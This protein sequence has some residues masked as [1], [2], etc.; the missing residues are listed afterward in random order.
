M[1]AEWNGPGSLLRPRCHMSLRPRKDAWMASPQRH[2]SFTHD[3]RPIFELP[4]IGAVLWDASGRV[5]EA[6]ERF[7]EITGYSRE[8]LQSGRLDWRRMTPVEWSSLDAASISQLLAEGSTREVEKE[9]VHR[10]GHRVVVQLSSVAVPG[11]GKRFLSLVVDVTGRRLAEREREEALERE[12]TA[13]EQAEAA[14]R[15]RDEILA[16]VSHDLRNPLGTISMTAGLLE[17]EADDDRRRT[18][19]D[20]LRRAVSRMGRL[21]HDL[22]DVNQIESGKLVISPAPVDA[23]SLMDEARPGLDLEAAQNRQ[24]LEWSAPREPLVVM[25][26]HV[27]IAQVIANLVGNALKFTPPAGGITVALE[28]DGDSARFCITDTGPGIDEA[29][30]PHIF[31]RFYQASGRPRRGGV[32]LGLAIAR[33]IVDAHGGELTVARRRGEGTT[34]CFTIPLACKGAQGPHAI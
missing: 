26:D 14:V 7:L 31:D 5:L 6:N 18:Q 13:R 8:D 27:R 28:R 16:I 20:I 34:F 33:G 19:V 12:R 15:S 29:D 32:G 17:R 9:Y 23:A 21:I 11:P 30:L 1:E 4:V 2:E 25:A 22:L 10:E 3:L 24:R